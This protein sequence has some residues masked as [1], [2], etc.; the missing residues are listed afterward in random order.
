MGFRIRF[1]ITLQRTESRNLG[2][3]FTSAWIIRG[4]PV[5][6]LGHSAGSASDLGVNLQKIAVG[7]AEEQRPMPKRLVRRRRQQR[8]ALSHQL[9]G[10]LVDLGRGHPESQLQRGASYRRRRVASRPAWP[11][12][13]ESV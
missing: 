9:V 1:T 2:L 7:V 4:F 3:S 12:Q 13:S 11:R 6:L 10:A 8:H 5:E